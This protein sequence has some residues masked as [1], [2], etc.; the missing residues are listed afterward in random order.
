MLSV[1]RQSE[2]AATDRRISP[3]GKAAV[4][5][6]TGRGMAEDRASV[7][8]LQICQFARR[9]EQARAKYR[10]VRS[11]LMLAARRR[12]VVNSRR[13]NRRTV[14]RISGASPAALDDDA[15]LFSATTKYCEYITMTAEQRYKDQ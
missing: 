12:L 4:L 9:Y 2:L 14:R 3:G 6:L 15:T 11:R 5:D 10:P 1:T 13:K 7:Q 8:L